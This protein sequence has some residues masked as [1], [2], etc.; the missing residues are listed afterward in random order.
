MFKIDSCFPHKMHFTRTDKWC[1]KIVFLSAT[2]IRTMKV[3]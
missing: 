3:V 1:L 2:V